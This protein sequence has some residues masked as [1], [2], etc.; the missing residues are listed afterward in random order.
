MTKTG[1]NKHEDEADEFAQTNL[2]SEN[3]MKE[4]ESLMPFND[5]VVIDF[6][7]KHGINPAIIIGRMCWEMDYYAIKTSI[8]KQL[9]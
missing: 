9:N 3:Q 1:K 8:N 4:L 2:I 6:A 5:Q 7:D